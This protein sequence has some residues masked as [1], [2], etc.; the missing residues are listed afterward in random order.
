L[1]AESGPER[2]EERRDPA[3][4]EQRPERVCPNCGAALLKRK[5]KL[6][7]QDPARGYYMSYSD[8]Y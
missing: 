3:R 1:T 5:C 2:E 8:F 6:L 4:P 7:C